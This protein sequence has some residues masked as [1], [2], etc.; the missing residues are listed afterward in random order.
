MVVTWEGGRSGVFAFALGVGVGSLAIAFL[1][2]WALKPV[3]RATGRRRA[4]AFVDEWWVWA[5]VV[6]VVG[7]TF[8]FIGV[9][10]G[11]G[12]LAVLLAMVL[13][14]RRLYPHLQRGR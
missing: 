9:L 14:T 5:P 1:L 13:Q 6:T 11:I 8:V 4:E 3:F 12:V 2:R 7:G 10:P